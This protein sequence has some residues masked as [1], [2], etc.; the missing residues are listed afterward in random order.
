MTI[1]GN[2]DDLNAPNKYSSQTAA[3]ATSRENLLYKLH[4]DV[5]LL[6]KESLQIAIQKNK[7]DLAKSELEL[8]AAVLKYEKEKRLG[9]LELSFREKELAK[10]PYK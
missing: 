3:P 10:M 6:Q 7:N 5:L 4:N 2:L 8:K 1:S 9:E